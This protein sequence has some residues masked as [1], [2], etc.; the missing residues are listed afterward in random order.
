MNRHQA[1]AIIDRMQET[2]ATLDAALRAALAVSE[3][4]EGQ[5]ATDRIYGRG[6]RHLAPF[7]YLSASRKFATLQRDM[8]SK[9]FSEVCGLVGETLAVGNAPL[10]IDESGALKE[11]WLG[12]DELRDDFGPRAV[13]DDLWRESAPCAQAN[14]LRQVADAFVR[15]FGLDHRGE[16]R[17]VGAFVVLDVRM[18][19][20]SIA[21]KYSQRNEYGSDQPIRDGALALAAV[22][23]A[24][25]P[26]QADDLTDFVRTMPR[27][28]EPG[29]RPLCAIKTS[30]GD[31]ILSTFN[32]KAEFRIPAAAAEA[33]N[34]FV[35][36]HRG[37]ANRSAA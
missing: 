36:E 9:V 8:A 22:F 24:M 37:E 18:Y 14:G 2:Y 21:K 16:V 32:E 31:I 13:F 3:E 12:A 7:R 35:A 11:R 19:L 29:Y 17:R 25:A 15:A 10:E 27:K 34:L 26:G 28:F 1:E 4:A 33:I 5:D 6:P 20:C 30:Y 23:A